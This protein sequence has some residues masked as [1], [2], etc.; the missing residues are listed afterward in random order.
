MYVQGLHVAF[1][2]AICGDENV[3][4]QVKLLPSYQ[5]RVVDVQ[6]DDVGL[7]ATGC[8]YKPGG[9]KEEAKCQKKHKPLTKI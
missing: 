4:T 3:E 8:C 9:E 7:F 1:Q 2:R 6:G 5:Q